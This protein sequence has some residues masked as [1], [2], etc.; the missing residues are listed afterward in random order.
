VIRLGP[1]VRITAR[2]IWATV[3][4]MADNVTPLVT[5]AGRHPEDRK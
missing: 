4:Q 5:D 2:P 3:A 1:D